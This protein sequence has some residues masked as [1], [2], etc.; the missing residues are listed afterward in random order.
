[1][2]KL[3]N[4]FQPIM[5]GNVEVRNR[6][7][8]AP[9]TDNF[10][11]ND[12]V[13]DRMKAFYAER[14]EGG[15]GL[16]NIGF[17]TVNYPPNPLG[18]GMYHDK[19]IA[20]IRE[21]TSVCHSHGAKVG[22]ELNF[23]EYL[24]KTPGGP[25]EL[26]GP[27]D[28]V[29]RKGKPK[30]R[31]LTIEEIEQVVD[32]YG[33]AARRAREGGFDIC[34]LIAHAG[35]PLSQFFSPLTNK[36]T[37]KYGG[38]FENRMRIIIEIIESIRKKAGNDYTITCRIGGQDFIPGG[39]TYEDNIRIAQL[40][41]SVGVAML[42][43]TTGWHDANVPFIPYYVPKGN[44]AYMA[45]GVKKHVN[46]PV[47][48][49]TRI[50]D[51]ILADKIIGEGRADMIYFARP[52]I[53]DPY[54]PKKAMEERFEEIVPCTSCCLCF[55][56]WAE[57]KPI[58]CQ[59]NAR[60]GYELE[61]NITPADKP[62]NVYVVGGGPAGMEAARVASLR[63]HK[64][65]LFEKSDMLGGALIAASAAPF[66]DGDE[67]LRK[68]LIRAVS[69]AGVE[70][71]LNTA[72]DAEMIA[73]AKPDEVIIA[74]GGTPIIPAIAGVDGKNVVT[75]VDL[76]TGKAEAGNKV[77]VIGGGMVGCEAADYLHDQGKDVVL[78]E[79]LDKIAVDVG[80]TLKWVVRQRLNN[81]GIRIL[82]GARAQ[83]ITDK[84]VR[85][86]HKGS[87]EFYEAETVVLAVGI[88]E[89][90]QLASE[91]GGMVTSLHKIGDCDRRARIFDAIESGF[92]VG[93]KV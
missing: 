42:N 56:R 6:I 65:T 10:G 15:A 59:V 76:L 81:L 73:A 19:F 52:L 20:G 16:I 28:V 7:E 31:P 68:Y 58:C 27:S 40:L 79:M 34:H 93:A 83:E 90:D 22:V 82:T 69:S 8:F 21:L 45:E 4:L 51:P 85:V 77:V 13:T 62:K 44:W 55:D 54:L 61:R 43:V 50:L 1:M 46:I 39:N 88:K 17:F 53:A 84:G 37:D 25:F 64:V 91:L 11:V 80:R 89:N 26:I 71:K 35:Y 92:V 72:V 41:E 3:K 70:V 24:A 9:V 23:E 36:R 14:A 60:A 29:V 66:K 57:T 32:Q 18:I 47:V 86:E 75:A 67:E 5:I 38:S 2:A 49:G 12:Y 63:G 48:T 33:E 30:P 87:T 78:I 74:T